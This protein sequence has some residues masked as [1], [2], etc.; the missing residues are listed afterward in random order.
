MWIALGRPI[1]G[2]ICNCY[3]FIR[4]VLDIPDHAAPCAD[5]VSGQVGGKA[6]AILKEIHVELWQFG[7]NKIA[8]VA[9]G[10]FTGGQVEVFAGCLDVQVGLDVL[11]AFNIPTGGVVG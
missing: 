10:L 6:I 1:S 3:L 2:S 11:P 8:E 5:C 7:G 9:Q 4:P